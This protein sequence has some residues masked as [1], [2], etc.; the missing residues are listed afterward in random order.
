[1]YLQTHRAARLRHG[2]ARTS[3]GSASALHS[4]PEE[5]SRL[6][7]TAATHPALEGVAGGGGAQQL[8]EVQGAVGHEVI[9]A[10]GG[11]VEDGELDLMAVGDR[12][13]ELLVVGGFVGLLLGAGLPHAHLVHADGD[14]GVQQLVA[15]TEE[16]VP[17]GPAGGLQPHRLPDPHLQVPA[18][19]HGSGHGR[20]PG[21]PGQESQSPLP[22]GEAPS[23]C[24][25][26]PPLL[27]GGPG[28]TGTAPGLCPGTDTAPAPG[29][30][31]APGLCSDTGSDTAPGLCPDTAPR[32]GPCRRC[33]CRGGA[34]RSGSGTP[35]R[36]AAGGEEPRSCEGGERSERTERTALPVPPPPR[37][38]PRETAQLR[39]TPTALPRSAA[40]G[41]GSELRL[42]GTGRGAT[43]AALL[44]A[45]RPARRTCAENARM[46]RLCHLVT[47]PP[48]GGSL[49]V[50]NARAGLVLGW[51]SSGV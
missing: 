51:I 13:R 22:P 33:R 28:G 4:F 25:R 49:R 19:L 7:R 47:A 17:E 26:A 41:K 38:G 1:M 23:L 35:G 12:G 21:A 42:L 50:V 11:V 6:L 8:L 16:R 45:A 18:E 44:P 48:F 32:P 10:D 40:P 24:C 43:G 14:I 15:L 20:A 31:T 3:P 29:T 27:L 2:H 39:D 9:V 30:D 46:C 34:P 36:G 37:C 5:L